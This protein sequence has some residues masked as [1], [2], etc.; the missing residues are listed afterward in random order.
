MK[1]LDGLTHLLAKPVLP[2]A[3]RH[4]SGAD[5][6]IAFVQQPVKNMKK[7]LLINII[8][9]TAIPCSARLGWTIQQCLDFYGPELPYS[10]R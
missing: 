3:S 5:V 4:W 1:K 7:F 9:L 6:V 8:L 10:P 2:E